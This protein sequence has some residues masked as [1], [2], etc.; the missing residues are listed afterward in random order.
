[1]KGWIALAVALAVGV[2][3]AGCQ[4]KADGQ[5]TSQAPATSGEDGVRPPGTRPGSDG[6]DG[7]PFRATLGNGATIELLALWRGARAAERI[8]WQPDGTPIDAGTYAALNEELD[9][10][11]AWG[12]VRSGYIF[13][14]TPSLPEPPPVRSSTTGGKPLQISRRAEDGLCVALLPVEIDKAG[15]EATDIGVSAAFGVWESFPGVVRDG[16]FS[17]TA[18]DSGGVAVTL[19][20]PRDVDAKAGHFVVDA[21]VDTPDLNVNIA[22]ARADGEDRPVYGFLAQNLSPAAPGLPPRICYSFRTG[23]SPSDIR[24]V[25]VQ[26]RRYHAVIFRNVSL[27]R[28]RHTHARTVLPMPATR[29]ATRPGN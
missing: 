20:G 27:Q 17:G 11:C 21:I 24:A 29:P 15:G 1:M 8:W 26:T 28:G 2:F 25:S 6:K 16:Q 14:Q 18:V 4:P 9:A 19:A 22:F 3:A 13:R 23:G 5:T 7:P 10:G 12:T